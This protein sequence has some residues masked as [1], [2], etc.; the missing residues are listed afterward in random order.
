MDPNTIVAVSSPAA[1]S[2]FIEWD[3]GRLKLLD[4]FYGIEAL[5][6]GLRGAISSFAPSTLGFDSIGSWQFFQFLI[7]I[8]PIYSIWYLESSRPLNARSPAYL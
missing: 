2:G 3:G 1:E 7:D 5:D 8:G 6:Q 4:S